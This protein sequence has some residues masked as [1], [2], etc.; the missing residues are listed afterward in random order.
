LLLLLTL[1]GAAFAEC[2]SD[3]TSRVLHAAG[4]VEYAFATLDEP[5]IVAAAGDLRLTL[6][7]VATQ[8]STPD[9]VAVHRAVAMIEFYEGKEDRA[10]QA[11]VAVHALQPAWEPAETLLPKGHDLQ[12]LW[13][14]AKTAATAETPLPYDAPGGWF[15]DGLQSKALPTG[16]PFIAQALA[17]D[18]AVVST[19]YYWTAELPPAA[20][21]GFQEG[22][23]PV[24][25][26][27]S[28]RGPIR[29]AGT[30][31]GVALAAG[32]GATWSMNSKARSD[33]AT[34]DYADILE[35]ESR[36]DTMTG[37]SI[38]LGA[39]AVAVLGLTWG[40]PW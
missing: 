7:C 26:K 23:A 15:V 5:A 30:A 19:E 17:G 8:L 29:I 12:V 40:V 20:K 14:E 35:L 31:A 32:A 2:P 3:A 33:M 1:A 36:A 34:A 28:A 21:L 6:P 27:K 11:W 24:A 13:E 10:K 25:K 16:R 39:G 22:G 38:G 9:A 18:G 4:R 37:A